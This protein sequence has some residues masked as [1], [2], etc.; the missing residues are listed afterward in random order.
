MAKVRVLAV[1]GELEMLAVG[2]VK[3]NDMASKCR[4][5]NTMT[6]EVSDPMPLQVALKWG[7]WTDPPKKTGK[8]AKGRWRTLKDGRRVMVTGQEDI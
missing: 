6:N 7:Y 8:K 1:R 4:I 2:K 3:P 5:R